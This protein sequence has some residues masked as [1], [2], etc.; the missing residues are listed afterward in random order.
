[1]RRSA[2]SD[3]ARLVT[4]VSVNT[5]R[6]RP[7]VSRSAVCHSGAGVD[8]V[9]MVRACGFITASAWRSNVT[10]GSALDDAAVS[11]SGTNVPCASSTRSSAHRCLHAPCS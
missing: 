3:V 8:F 11:S 10:C 9:S 7:L 5:D 1:M 4:R 2:G 6:W